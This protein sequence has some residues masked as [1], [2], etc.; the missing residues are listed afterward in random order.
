MMSSLL[1]NAIQLDISALGDKE[2]AKIKIS[3][4]RLWFQWLQMA[5][6]RGSDAGPGL[7]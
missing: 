2:N 4:D 3:K 6:L 1:T 5:S 7:K